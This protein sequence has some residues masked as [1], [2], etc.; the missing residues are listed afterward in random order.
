MKQ[1]IGL[2]HCL[3]GTVLFTTVTPT[4][5]CGPTSLVRLQIP[6]GVDRHARPASIELIITE[7]SIK[8]IS[9]YIKH[10]N[11]ILLNSCVETVVELMNYYHTYRESFTKTFCI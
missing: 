5:N 7:L 6:T 4:V 2:L 9:H 3:L 8:R 11:F 10:M 1:M